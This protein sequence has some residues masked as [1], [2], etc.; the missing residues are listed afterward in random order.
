MALETNSTTLSGYTL[1]L[2]GSTGPQG[3]TVPTGEVESSSQRPRQR[4]APGYKSYLETNVDVKSL[5]FQIFF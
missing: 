1:P 3:C 2:R 5:N 4:V